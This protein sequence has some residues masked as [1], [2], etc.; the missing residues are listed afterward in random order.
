M[1]EPIEILKILKIYWSFFVESA[2]DLF[3]KL[4]IKMVV[5]SDI[6]I[7]CYLGILLTLLVILFVVARKKKAR[8]SDPALSNNEVKARFRKRDRIRFYTTKMLRKVKQFKEDVLPGAEQE[9]KSVGKRRLKRRSN[10]NLRMLASNF[11][12]FNSVDYERKIREP[13][14]ALLEADLSESTGNETHLPA[15]VM[16]MLKS[17]RIFGNFEKP[18]FFALCKHVVSMTASA[19]KIIF[20]PGQM[21]ECIYIVKSGQ[22]NLNL[23]YKKGT[24]MLLKKVKA[25]ENIHSVMNI[26]DALRGSNFKYS[27]VIRAAVDS[28]I[29]MFPSRA[30]KEVF[31]DHPES[32]VRV[33][34]MIMLRLQQM[35]FQA[36]HKFLGLPAEIVSSH[37]RVNE[38]LKSLSVYSL[39]KDEK[40]LASCF[41]QKSVASSMGHSS[42]LISS[43]QE[44]ESESLFT[45]NSS[46][47]LLGQHKNSIKEKAIYRRTN[48]VELY[49]KTNEIHNG[50]LSTTSDF[51]AVLDRVGLEGSSEEAFQNQVTDD[52][53]SSSSIMAELEVDESYGIPTEK[54]EK[55]MTA[56]RADLVKLL[57]LPTPKLLDGLLTIDVVPCGTY[58]VKE[59]EKDSGLFFLVQG[60]LE[61]SQTLLNQKEVLFTCVPGE[62]MGSLSLLTG[63]PSF[64]TIY[65]KEVSY[66][67][68]ISKVNFYKLIKQHPKVVLPVA[69][70]VIQKM[71]SFIRN[72]DFALDWILQE[73]GKPLFRQND[74]PDSLYIVLN[75]R[76]RAVRAHRNGQKEIVHEYGRGEFVGL[77]EALTHTERTESVHAIRD[78][79]LAQI[80]EGLLSTIKICYPQVVSRLIQLLGERLITKMKRGSRLNVADSKLERVA[81]NLGTLAVIPASNS[82]PLHNFTFELGLAISDIGSTLVLTSDVIKQRLG[83]AVLENIHECNLSNWL[84]H[85]EDIHRIVVY[86]ADMTMTEWTKRCIRQA[87]AIMIVGRV[88]EDPQ[89]GKLEEQLERMTL[90]R[91]Q[92]DL[93][94]LH[95]EESFVQPT[96][97]LEWLNARE[98]VSAHYHIRCP[99][100]IF[101]R[102]LLSERYANDPNYECPSKHSDFARLARVLTGTSIGLVLGGGGARGIAHIGVIKALREADIP[103]DS[104]GGTSM[105]AFV[106]ALYAEQGCVVKTIQKCREGCKKMASMWRK[107][108]DMTYPYTSLFTGK[109]FNSEIH[110][111]FGDIKIEDM[112]LPYFCVTT[113]INDS[114]MKI[115]Q[116]GC[117]W[118][119]VRASMSLSG[120]LPPMCDP[121]DGH[122]LLDGG[123]VNNLPGDVMRSLGVKTIICVDVG[124]EDEV[125][126]TNF[127]DTLSGWWMLWNKFNP[128]ASPVRIP[129]MNGIQSRLAYVSC[130]GKLEEV[131]NSSFYNYIRPPI[132]RFKTLQFGSFDEILEC[133]YHH[134]KA[135]LDGLL[136]SD[137]L[138]FGASNEQNPK[139][140]QITVHNSTAPSFTDLAELVS[141]IKPA[142]TISTK[143]FDYYSEDDEDDEF[144][145]M[146]Y[147]RA[148]ASD[149]ECFTESYLSAPEEIGYESEDLSRL[150]RRRQVPRLNQI[151]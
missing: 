125:A 37:S 70:S 10:S 108:L 121:V 11:L 122:L 116:T 79:E 63:D 75:G 141:R 12:Q 2:E 15:E 39:E 72:I 53:V 97:T 80:P 59:G 140:K 146:E 92:K 150:R 78:T 101:K 25:G 19:G 28:E 52:F 87:D 144:N 100:K 124:S 112:L 5:Q 47:G 90:V 48:S 111:T 32:L 43:I 106:G 61:V 98:W 117:C 109:A 77:V 38:S 76:L 149:Q 94:L 120:Y 3:K 65:T 69:N 113:D 6:Y 126:L 7:L 104:I 105:G 31:E 142:A 41:P 71:S 151:S 102:K 148:T 54:E 35:I 50:L 115:H 145:K 95:D 137:R 34:Q 68:V 123:Y 64:F 81:K 93:I 44:H 119:Y 29:L 88:D 139:S 21:D 96:N 127:G 9:G 103:I 89:V 73:S 74:E 33:V 14:A 128:F 129:D 22:L 66:V 18:L 138:A 107:I 132:N 51:D 20:K 30:F 58:L 114:K 130:V 27:I 86:Q 84:S 13:P 99:K 16:Y 133:G 45:D 49:G 82:V 1:M 26:L 131:K 56:A 46:V 4:P 83:N 24:E 55:M 135:V 40:K 36:F 60:L 143:I 110:S 17:V 62:F 136:K 42:N 147:E 91:A 67:V 85:Q 23:V 8:Q 134:G 57:Q 118:R